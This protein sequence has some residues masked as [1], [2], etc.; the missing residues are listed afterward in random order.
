MPYTFTAEQ[1]TLLDEPNAF[2]RVATL[3]A[4]GS[5]QNTTIWYRREAD[6]L[7]IATGANALK[8][9][10]ALRD[11]RVAV[12]V[13]HPANPYHYLQIRGRAEVVRDSAASLAEF[14]LIARRYIGEKAD[15]WVDVFSPDYDGALM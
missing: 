1:R 6:A 15:A 11:P 12:V 5:P 4:D 13:E 14:R 10:N 3:M 7:I 8:V 9:R 2:A